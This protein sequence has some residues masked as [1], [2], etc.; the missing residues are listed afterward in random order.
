MSAAGSFGMEPLAAAEAAI[1]LHGAGQGLGWDGQ[2]RTSARPSNARGNAL[3]TNQA[4][5]RAR[6]WPAGAWADEGGGV[7]AVALPDG[8][9]PGALAAGRRVTVTIRGRRAEVELRPPPFPAYRLA[10]RLPGPA[11]PARSSHEV[12]HGAGRVVLR[13]RP[14]E[15]AGGAAAAWGPGRIVQEPWEGEGAKKKKPEVS[16]AKY[17]W[18]DRT[19][20]VSVYLT[21]P[22]VHELPADRV[23]VR[24]RELSLDVK[25]EAADKVHCFAIT[26]LPLE[27]VV[28]KSSWKTK[29]DQLVLTLRKWAATSWFKLQLSR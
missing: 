17:S 2:T 5:P 11:C 28:D 29:P 21:I 1:A 7:V 16:V 23:R 10:L 19:Q 13:L 20:S 25:V 22:G 12:Q 26:E 6:P 8:V 14:P 4:P 27:I 24:F 3:G 18:L 9:D 15:G